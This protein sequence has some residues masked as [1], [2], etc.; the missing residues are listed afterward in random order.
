MSFARIGRR[1]L[2]ILGLNRRPGDN[3]T[4]SAPDVPI[5]PE[6]PALVT[7]T[8]I[9]L[10]PDPTRVIT[11]FFV[12]GREDVGPGDSRAAPVTER[13]LALREAD[14]AATMRSIDERFTT[15]HRD[16]HATFRDHAR[17]VASRIKDP[18]ELSDDRVL[19]LGASFT[20]EYAIEG[21]ALCNPSAV[22]APNESADGVGA[23]R[24]VLSV[25]GIGEGHVSSIGFRTGPFPAIAAGVPGEHH[26]SVLQARLSALGPDHENVAHVLD[27]LPECF[28]DAAL[29]AR[30]ASLAEDAATRRDT[31]ATI[32]HLRAVSRSSYCVDFPTA[33]LLSERVLWPHTAE[34]RRGMEDARFVRFIDEAT[35]TYYATYTAFD[36]TNV[37]QHL[38][39]TDD[40]VSFRC[41]PMAGAAATGKGLALFPRKV[42]GRYVALSR[43]DRETNA[44]AFSDDLYCWGAAEPI[45]VPLRAWEV[46]QLGNC[47]SPIETEAGWLVLTHGVGPMRT[48]ALGAILLDLHDPR[49]VLAR[50]AEPFIA[51]APTER[52]GYVPNVVYTCG[53]FAHGDV[54]VVPY[55]V[56]D[57]SI[58]IATLSVR[59]LVRSL[60]REG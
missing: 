25:R 6:V 4:A 55:G 15:S 44:I 14:V 38:I 18:G 35:V 51:P 41:G 47:G 12:P 30:I 27:P 28:D 53:A 42:G 5:E 21:A 19:L 40:F 49:R 9:R 31:D 8:G 59:A 26:R 39:E 57:Q 36:G 32:A 33:T 3:A 23:A 20:H 54:L 16:L 43:S 22:L 11:R 17:M 7:D 13:I 24:F 60:I 56:G 48:Y 1:L 46:L 45:Q 58:A 50:S 37:V 52:G 34:E 2:S 29:E 10:R